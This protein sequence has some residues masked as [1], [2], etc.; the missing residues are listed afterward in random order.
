MGRLGPRFARAE[1]RRRARAFLLGLLAGL[2]RADCWSIAEHAG[3]VSPDG[4]QHLLTGAVWDAAAVRGDLRY[5]GGMWWSTG[6]T[7]TRCY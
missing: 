2:P 7:R 1:P 5:V 3:D 4:M 6:A